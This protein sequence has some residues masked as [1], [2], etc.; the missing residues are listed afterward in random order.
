MLNPNPF[1]EQKYPRASADAAMEIAF[2]FIRKTYF[3]KLPSRFESVFAFETIEEC[4]NF[5]EKY[6]YK[7]AEN[8]IFKF[9]SDHKGYK[10]DMY[11]LKF[12][13]DYMGLIG[14]AFSYWSGEASDNP[15]WEI[16]VKL[17]VKIEKID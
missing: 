6:P 13:N 2:E 4:K 10:F 14:N 16:I 7:E 3:P 11:W 15:S 9:I 1:E 17:P 12:S 5:Q 8:N